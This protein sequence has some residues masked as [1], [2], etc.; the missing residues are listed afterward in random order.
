MAKPTD[1]KLSAYD[2]ITIKYKDE[3]GDLIT[4]FD[5]SDLSFAIQ[6]SRILK[7]QILLNSKKESKLK[8]LSHGDIN[9]IKQQLR[10]IR[11]EVNSILENL[12]DSV[13]TAINTSSE[14]KTTEPANKEAAP[15]AN[16]LNKVNSSEFDPLQEGKAQKNGTVPEPKENVKSSAANITNSEKPITRPQSVPSLPRSNEPVAV[17]TTG[18]SVNQ[19]QQLNEYYNRTT[20][21]SYAQMPYGS[22]PY[23]PHHYGYSAAG[24]TQ[25]VDTQGPNPSSYTNPP[26]GGLP[27]SGQPQQY[28]TPGGVYQPGQPNPYSKGYTQ[29]TSQHYLPP[30]Q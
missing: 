18:A 15:L 4:I 3:D 2:D 21:T 6:C 25:Q 5:S 19:S 22:M 30:R 7:L 12:D 8:I 29:P 13:S 23:P 14:P 24:Y 16:T 11:N 17:S 9:N 20:A 26:Q 28:N 1:G 10:N 27:Y